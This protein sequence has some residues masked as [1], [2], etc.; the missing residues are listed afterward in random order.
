[1]KNIIRY[2][3][4]AHYRLSHLV[5]RKEEEILFALHGY[6]QLSEYFLKKLRP[7]FSDER[8]IVVPEATNYAYLEGFSGRVGSNWMTKHERESA[9]A[10]NINYL[11]TLLEAILVKYTHK[12]LLKVLGFSQGAATATRWVSQLEYPVKTLVLWGG[13]FAHDLH[14]VKTAQKL[15][16]SKCYLAIG[17]K[18][19]IITQESL[20][21][22][23][24]L[25]SALGVTADKVSYSGGHD[26]DISVLESLIEENK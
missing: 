14:P 18:D 25:I 2:E 21:K 3:H 8:L 19:E 24:A 1:M 4:Q 13:G 26:L 22:Q 11:N 6:G 7:I 15:N 16:G 20:E 17:D 9:I 23:E 12:P 10:N 5:N